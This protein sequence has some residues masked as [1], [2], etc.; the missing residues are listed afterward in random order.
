[1]DELYKIEDGVIIYSFNGED[2][3]ISFKINKKIGWK[4][5]GVMFMKEI[6]EV[7]NF[8]FYKMFIIIGVLLLLGG[9]VILFIFK[10]II[11]L[12]R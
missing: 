3:N 4:I 11:I 2:W 1:M 8:I 5:V 7:I 6:E 12:L 9:I 10:F